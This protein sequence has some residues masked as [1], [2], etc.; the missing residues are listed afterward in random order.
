MFGLVACLFRSKIKSN[1]KKQ[2]SF[3]QAKNVYMYMILEFL[4][5]IRTILEFLKKLMERV[6]FSG[7]VP[8]I[9]LEI[10]ML[11]I[12]T[13]KIIKSYT[14]IHFSREHF[15]FFYLRFSIFHF[16]QTATRPNI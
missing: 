1:I 4:N 16:N 5:V 15:S 8:L 10:L 9:F 12:E 13:E 6:H 14:Y 3:T 11:G 2:G 7:R